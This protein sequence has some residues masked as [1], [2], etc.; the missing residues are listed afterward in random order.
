MELR[1][2][3]HF[4]EEVR[5]AR[6]QNM[7]QGSARSQGPSLPP[8]IRPLRGLPE[9]KRGS[10]VSLLPGQNN[11]TVVEAR[12]PEAEVS[13]MLTLSVG[14]ANNGD[15]A[16]F[17]QDA[18]LIG[19][20]TWGI[21]GAHF[22]SDLD[23]LRGVTISLPANYLRFSA[24]Y[25]LANLVPATPISY[26][27]SA[28][29]AYGSISGRQAPVRLTNFLTD[30]V[31]GTEFLPGAGGST[32]T[33]LIPKWAVSFTIVTHTV[34]AGV[35]NP[36][37]LVTLTNGAGTKFN[38]YRI[39]DNTNTGNQFETMFPI[40]NGMDRFFVS[41]PGANDTLASII[42]TLGF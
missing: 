35:P 10:S 5:T 9:N 1:Q 29:I 33:L 7:L 40:Q 28:G 25:P 27:V 13:E 32:G 21:A 14:V 38:S 19:H 30:P 31:A 8:E 6:T 36:N 18:E 2:L 22:E 37:L 41:N 42:W 12:T 23:I 15:V 16:N 11:V 4:Y 39:V 24:S 34:A 20:V 17:L 26:Q 3:A